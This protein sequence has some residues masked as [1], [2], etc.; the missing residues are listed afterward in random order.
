MSSA[1]VLDYS[2]E[3]VHTGRTF[4]EGNLAKYIKKLKNVHIF[5]S[6]PRTFSSGKNQKWRPRFMFKELGCNIIYNGK[7]LV[8]TY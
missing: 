7:N 4:L 5:Y 2:E 1:T 3:R 6:R 8:R